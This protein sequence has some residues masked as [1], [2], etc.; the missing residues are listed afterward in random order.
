MNSDLAALAANLDD[1]MWRLS[2]LY[3]I[4][5]KDEAGDESDEGLVLQFKPNLAQ[6]RL[7]A[8][9]WNRNIILKARQL[10][11]TTLIAILWLDTA[12]FSK[13]PIRC[14]IVAQ[15]RDAAVAIFRDKVKFAY[16]N[17]PDVLRDRFPLEA[18]SSEEILFKHNG[19]SIR[20]A[21]SY[22]GG[23][24]HRLHISEFGK[25]C[26][27]YPDKA[28]EVITGSL[29]AVPKSGIC[30]IES[31]AEGQDGAFYDMT[32]LARAQAEK[33]TP[34]TVKDW[35]FHFFPWWEAGEYELDPEGVVFTEADQLYFSAI[36][37]QIKR[38]LS[39]RQRAWYVTTRRADFADDAP[40]MWQEYPGTPK[41][42]F[43]VSIEGCY[44]STQLATA[45]THGRVLPTLPV[46]SAPVNT[47]WDI[48][49]GDMTAIWFHQ[50]VGPENRFV[51]YY[52]NS[53]EELQH[54]VVY[55]Q[56]LGYVFGVHYLPHEA[57]AKRIGKTPDTNQSIKEMLEELMPGQRFEIVPRVTEIAWGI[58]ATRA[59]FAS[60]WFSE[61]G[62]GRGLARLAGYRKTWNKTLG[63]W[64]DT[65]VHND[66]S[67]GADAFRQYGQVLEAGA[68]FMTG[69]AV[70]V[71]PGQ[72][73]FRRRGSSMAV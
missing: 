73:A 46:E 40:T 10:G 48:G 47:F 1:P 22:R 71:R 67:H 7:L 38:P 34:L 35:R 50:H 57:D 61:A 3:K 2:N 53:G 59:S 65:P 41:E 66:D 33:G 23:T 26:A 11:F 44:Y 45:R 68:T 39:L 28:R 24:P 51:R 9:L 64:S 72:G 21:T 69:F 14:G 32:E 56:G 62:C 58:Q 63:C 30:V 6:R 19:A 70:P 36:E 54:Y 52:E 17:L 37:G 29:P 16:Q 20:V 15:D 12:L 42:A 5:V 25:I 49:R 4:I 27:K 60:A 18:D 55:M 43:Q 8:R 13:G 31:T